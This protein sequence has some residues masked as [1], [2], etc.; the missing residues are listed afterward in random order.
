MRSIVPAASVALLLIT[1]EGASPQ[2]PEATQFTTT[3]D[4]YLSRLERSDSLSGTVL[5]ARD[6]H[7]IF[8]HSYGKANVELSVPNSNNTRYRIFSTTKQFTAAAVLILAGEGRIDL[9]AS[10]LKY[11]PE[12]PS[13]W[14]GATVQEML[15]HTSGIPNEENT[16]AQT[17]MQNDVKTQ[18]A[19][20]ALVAPKLAGHRLTD[21]P[22][23]K[24]RYN[25]FAYDL[26]ACI[27]A[28]VSNQGYASFVRE[29][30]FT[31]A[32]MLDAGFDDRRQA[33]GGMYVGS[34]SIPRLASGYNGTPGNLMTAFPQMFASRG[35]GGIYAT[36]EDLFHYDN[37]ISA[38][39]I[40]PPEL[41]RQAVDSAYS[42]G[43]D[44]AYGY[45]WMISRKDSITVVH[46]SGGTNGYV[47]DY[48]RYPASRICIVILT[49]R[50]F[51][52]L[53]PIRDTIFRMVS[54]PVQASGR[55]PGA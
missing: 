29:H 30:I 35:A 11:L 55:R 46:H 34:A 50:G 14:Q 23:S 20:L 40:V 2:T 31:P 25:N 45:G 6:G 16:W 52:N 51:T 4:S 26:L 54:S 27:V 13:E 48:A 47:A 41:E 32:G 38:G 39:R 15:T 28:R 9:H 44:A 53:S 22:G 8:E 36:A 7:I 3:V 49:N 33:E 43:P 37:A 10:V 21:P 19:N 12:L 42:T 1:S 17:F 5:I 24:W 18:L